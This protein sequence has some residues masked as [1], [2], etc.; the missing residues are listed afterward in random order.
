MPATSLSEHSPQSKID[1][2]IVRRISPRRRLHAAAMLAC[3]T[4]LLPAVTARGQQPAA[5]E[6]TPNGATADRAS[7]PAGVAEPSDAE[8]ISAVQNLLNG[9]TAQR[10]KLERNLEQLDEEFQR[11]SAEF[12]RLDAGFPQERKIAIDA[13]TPRAELSEAERA[14]IDA[15]DNFNVTLARRKAVVQQIATLKER[16][17]LE[18]Q[19]IE[20][21]TSSEPEPA[22]AE[23]STATPA[24][25][26]SPPPT[27]PDASAAE[28]STTPPQ[29]VG[30]AALL[31]SGGKTSAETP[32]ATNAAASS[33]GTAADP[34]DEQVI[35]DGQ[36]AAARKKLATGQAALEIAET[37]VERLTA[38]EELFERDLA[39]AEELVEADRRELA[40]ADQQ[41]QSIT[42]QLA[43]TPADD[44]AERVRLT[45]AQ[46]AARE[47][48]TEA[49]R[50]VTDHAARV[51]ELQTQ[52]DQLRE[53]KTAALVK[54][55]DA[56]EAVDS[57]RFWVRFYESPA[58]PH[59]VWRWITKD[60]P[61]VLVI[62]VVMVLLW[63]LSRVVG[64]RVIAELALR[65][66]RGSA[67]E[68]E[69]RADTLRRVFQS[70]ASVAILA[71]GALALLNQTGFDITVLLGGAA[72][73]GAAVAFGSQNLIKDY[74]SGFMILVENQYSVG[75]V[76]RIGDI[77]GT[78]EDVTLRMTVLRDLEGV[79]HFVPHSQVTTVS[80]LTHGWSR[81]VFDVG[82]GYGEN[83][84]RVMDV[85]MNLAREL[86]D[87][88]TFGP[89]ML[90]EPEML[91]VDKFADSA[92]IIRFIVK[93]R[94]LKQWNVKRE[95]LRRIKNEFDKLGIEIPYPHRTV[96][97]RDLDVRLMSG[98]G[99]SEERP[100]S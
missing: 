43:Q 6:T 22:K 63:W 27:A 55:E 44:E 51:G 28:A 10:A 75:N 23:P 58:A 83:V 16:I 1:G 67:V 77:A 84:D 19:A 89:M 8:R 54:V 86:R 11:T 91:G 74:F 49:Q 80:N 46:T 36:L 100:A 33:A 14:W 93:T 25:V 98:E 50:N 66:R 64:R 85:L 29:A 40:I 30:P 32:A 9:D 99:L 61:K 39:N 57:E 69:M 37:Q 78:V 94:P 81:V 12:N 97:H 52:L 7:K 70:T 48:L 68:R 5:P 2:A 88:E 62:L 96:Y 42:E 3:L 59:R 21:L 53:L 95:L 18:T 82:V 90:G 13:D 72:V 38:A 76:I 60:G 65:S 47:R 34:S 4:S 71:L 87:D 73:I 45:E 56:S 92:V 41:L 26:A 20:R 15:R 24:T 35:V 79:V 31:L 17:T